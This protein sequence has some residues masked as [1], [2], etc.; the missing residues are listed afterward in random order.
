VPTQPRHP[1]G[2]PTGGQ[3]ASQTAAESS[4]EL[5]PL[6]QARVTL[7]RV[8]EQVAVPPVGHEEQTW[9]PPPQSGYTRRERAAGGRTYQSAVPAR[10][11]DLK[12]NLPAGLIAEAEE[13]ASEIA[14]FDEST[15]HG[16]GAIT[17]VRLR[18][19]DSRGG[20]H[21]LRL[22]QRRRH[23]RQHARDD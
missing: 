15:G 4:V 22:R 13:A 19:R 17:A 3:I 14:R 7:P 12:L 23:R 10:I 1:A 18:P 21:R 20:A 11:G 16:L 8:S 2:S 6:H 5:T 9:N